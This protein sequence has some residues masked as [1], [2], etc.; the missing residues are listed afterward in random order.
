MERIRLRSR[1]VK[2]GIT[3]EYRFRSWLSELSWTRV[4]SRRDELALVAERRTDL[5]HP[6][7]IGH[8]AGRAAPGWREA[9]DRAIFQA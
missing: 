6:Y 3:L 7:Q 5:G 2:S 9:R 8:L 1:G 4:T